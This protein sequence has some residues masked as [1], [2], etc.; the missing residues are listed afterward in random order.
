MWVQDRR[1]Q[2]R[3]DPDHDDDDAKLNPAAY[4]LEWSRPPHARRATVRICGE[5]RVLPINAMGILHVGMRDDGRDVRL[6]RRP[7]F[8]LPLVTALEVL[9]EVEVTLG[10]PTGLRRK[11][12]PPGN[13]DDPGRALEE[14]PR[15]TIAR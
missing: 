5:G 6:A 14:C 2:E 8:V 7:K 9:V 3:D 13:V 12:L 1:T 10:L 4:A 11:T 15:R